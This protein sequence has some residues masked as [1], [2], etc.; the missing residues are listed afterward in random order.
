MCLSSTAHIHVHTNTQTQPMCTQK[1]THILRLSLLP[2][3]CFM[4]DNT[5]NTTALL[6]AYCYWSHTLL[7]ISSPLG[8]H[9]ESVSDS[10]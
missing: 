9:A 5:D 4:T 2:R 8:I 10:I 7:L 1:L 6:T 3:Y